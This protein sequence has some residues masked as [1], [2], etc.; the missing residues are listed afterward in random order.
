MSRALHVAFPMRESQAI[1]AEARARAVKPYVLVSAVMKVLTDDVSLLD[2]V[3]DGDGIETLAPGRAFMLNGLTRNQG[4]VL[5][6]LANGPQDIGVAR[7]GERAIRRRLPDMQ[8]QTVRRSLEVLQE[9][10]LIA[11]A[12]APEGWT[13]RPW[14]LTEAGWLVA[15]TLGAGSGRR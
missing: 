11:L 4:A 15:A 13:R 10:G 1:R 14:C 12:D 2:A 8:P 5:Y 3:L 7:Y 6:V 9:R